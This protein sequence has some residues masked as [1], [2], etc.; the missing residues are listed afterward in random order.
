MCYYEPH[1]VVLPN[2]QLNMTKLCNNTQNSFVD[3]IT[4]SNDFL[5]SS[6]ITVER[7]VAVTRRGQS[8]QRRASAWVTVAA[9]VAARR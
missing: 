6:S 4:C 5:S 2:Q 7:I 1:Y 3:F 9:A 8:C